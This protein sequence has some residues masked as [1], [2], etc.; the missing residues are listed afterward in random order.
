V[1]SAE[2]LHNVYGSHIR[3]LHLTEEALPIVLPLPE[4]ARCGQARKPAAEKTEN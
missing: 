4:T 1:L 3:V 2:L